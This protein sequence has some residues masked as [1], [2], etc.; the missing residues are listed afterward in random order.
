VFINPSLKTS[1]LKR[2]VYL[3]ASAIFGILINYFA[4]FAIQI[5][6]LQWMLHSDKNVIW[7][8]GYPP[9]LILLISFFLI[10]AT[11]GFM[12]GRYWWKIIYIEHKYK[13]YN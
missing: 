3:I 11:W 5:F 8:S 7:Y 12:A 13:K 4:L 2:G 10:G 6:I 9:T 1:K